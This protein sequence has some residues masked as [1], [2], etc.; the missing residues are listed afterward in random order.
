MV[1]VAVA[2]FHFALV[3]GPFVALCLSK[4]A[5][6]RRRAIWIGAMIAALCFGSI[7]AMLL[8]PKPADPASVELSTIMLWS[9]VETLSTAIAAWAVYA[10]F[11]LRTRAVVAKNLS[12]F[13][14][15]SSDAIYDFASNPANLPKWATGIPAGAKVEFA[16]HNHLGILDHCVTLPSGERVNVPL[17]VLPKGRGSEVVFTLIPMPGMTEAQVDA[18]AKL[19]MR[20]LAALK[21][22]VEG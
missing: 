21:K 14:T 2:A 4:R 3:F 13:I 7:P 10:A 1:E 22:A 9:T 6:G 5:S 17:R 12:V 19:V 15:A 20:D 18:D 8:M 11:L 16:E